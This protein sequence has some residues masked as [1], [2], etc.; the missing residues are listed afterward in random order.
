MGYGCCAEYRSFL[1]KEEKIGMLEEYKQ[2]L[3]KEVKG[4][5]EKIEELRKNN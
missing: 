1:T 4:I 5:A 2:N 3:E